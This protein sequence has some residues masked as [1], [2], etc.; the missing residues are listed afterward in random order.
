MTTENIPRASCIRHPLIPHAAHAFVPGSATLFDDLFAFA[1][2]LV[3]RAAAARLASRNGFRKPPCARRAGRRA[4]RVCVE[5]G[6]EGGGRRRNKGPQRVRLE[7]KSRSS[8]AARHSRPAA[9]V[10][11]HFPSEATG[12]PGGGRLRADGAAP[13][14]LP[15]TNT[16]THTHTRPLAA[17]SAT[18]TARICR[19]RRA[20]CYQYSRAWQ[21]LSTTCRPR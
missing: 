1:F 8:L 11:R 15:T 16:H 5:G 12:R 6:Q 20:C 10:R 9:R 18:P 14:S 3:P 13:S 2:D 19:L 4:V 7:G 21:G 17:L